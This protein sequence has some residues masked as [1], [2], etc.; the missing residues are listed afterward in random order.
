MKTTTTP[1]TN[2]FG[3]IIREP[4]AAQKKRAAAWTPFAVVTK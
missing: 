3:Q 1:K 2:A 4:S